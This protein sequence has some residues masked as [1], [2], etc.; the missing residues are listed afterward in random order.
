MGNLQIILSKKESG[1]FLKIQ[2]GVIGSS[3]EGTEGKKKAK[4]IG[5]EIAK[6]GCHLL[7]GGCTGLPYAAVKGAKEKGGVTVG[8]SPADSR[9]EHKEKYRYPV[10]DHDL[11]IFTGAGFKGRNVILVRSCD[12]VIATSGSMGTLNE[13]TIAHDEKKII[14][15]LKGVPG[16]AE[17]FGQIS[18][19]LGRPGRKIVSSENPSE[20]V[21]KVL[22]NI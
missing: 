15:L 22:Q 17:E 12:A 4:Q 6:S 13:L 20:L 18:E 21:G 11:L 1:G 9:E 2:I 10:E 8:I 16:A 19:K 3:Q 14:G 7:T 5:R